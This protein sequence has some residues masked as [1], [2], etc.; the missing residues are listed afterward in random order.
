MF[1]PVFSLSPEIFTASNPTKPHIDRN[2]PRNGIEYERFRRRWSTGS[3]AIPTLDFYAGCCWPRTVDSPA[4][5][6][7]GWELAFVVVLVPPLRAPA[8]SPPE[9]PAPFDLPYLLVFANPSAPPDPPCFTLILVRFSV[10]LG[11]RS[12]CRCRLVPIA[13]R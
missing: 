8:T 13:S 11:S 5:L 3:F 6:V 10:N 1:H 9:P 2:V 4:D 7:V 12:E